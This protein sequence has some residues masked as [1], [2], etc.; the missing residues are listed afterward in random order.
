VN[1]PNRAGACVLE[2]SETLYSPFPPKYK[3][4]WYIVGSCVAA[5]L[6]SSFYKAGLQIQDLDWACHQREFKDGGDCEKFARGVT[7]LFL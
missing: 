5:S 6:G 7:T 2:A 1:N 3:K 4:P